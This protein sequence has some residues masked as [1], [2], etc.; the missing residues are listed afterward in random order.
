MFEEARAKYETQYVSPPSPPSPRAQA[1]E[2]IYAERGSN[3]GTENYERHKSA[4]MRL[5]TSRPLE[6][7]RIEEIEDSAS[8]NTRTESLSQTTSPNVRTD[9]RNAN[10]EQYARQLAEAQAHAAWKRPHAWTYGP[11]M[12]AGER[13]GGGNNSLNGDEE[14]FPR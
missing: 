10:S 8:S 2:A 1:T 7:S 9:L 11:P 12:Q 6:R 5:D 4:Q 13:A 3:E 14:E